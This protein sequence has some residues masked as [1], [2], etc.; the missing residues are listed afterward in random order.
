MSGPLATI[1]RKIRAVVTCVRGG[2]QVML[3]L[4]AI[5][6]KAEVQFSLFPICQSPSLAFRAAN[7]PGKKSG[8]A[9]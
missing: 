6:S 4:L 1:A 9:S 2:Q 7:W 8:H 3:A 5:I